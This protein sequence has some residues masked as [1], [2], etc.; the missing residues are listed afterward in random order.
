MKGKKR[1]RAA[2]S[3]SPQKNTV[4]AQTARF[5]Q[6][7]FYYLQAEQFVKMSNHLICEAA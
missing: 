2:F 5:L 4:T 7:T 6:R 3:R 1:A